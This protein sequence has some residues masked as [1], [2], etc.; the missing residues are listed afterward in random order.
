[1]RKYSI[2]QWHFYTNEEDDILFDENPYRLS[3]FEAVAEIDETKQGNVFLYRAELTQSSMMKYIKK[4]QIHDISASSVS[5]VS[6]VR[7]LYTGKTESEHLILAIN[8]TLF[9]WRYG[10]VTFSKLLKCLQEQE[11]FY[12][13]KKRVTLLGLGDV[14][15]MLAIGIK[16]LG[17]E[18]IES[19]GVFDI[20]EASKKRWEMELNQIDVNPHLRIDAIDLDGLFETDVFVF[21]ASKF[22]P[23]VGEEVRDVRM[24]QYDLNAELIE[25]YAQMARKAN[26]KGIFA[27]VSDPVDL[28]CNKAF[29]S[30]QR[31]PE[32]LEMD[33]LGL[34]PEQV[35]GFGLGVMDARAK[36]YSDQMGLKYRQNG[37]VFGQHGRDLVVSDNVTTED[38]AQGIA[39]THKVVHSNLDMRAL[40]YK[41]FIAPAMSSGAISI[42]KMLTGQWHYSAQFLNGIYWG[43]SYRWLSHGMQ[44]E[45]PCVSH[46]LLTRIEE[47]Y[48]SL[49]AIWASLS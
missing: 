12:L 5:S 2:D 18:G 48:R 8:L 6:P 41:P 42:V 3:P 39:L 16:L 44:I 1:M 37:R 30:S 49:E 46:A 27:V 40:G 38:Q 34:L 23:K 43:S 13:K 24:V 28:L 31:H 15:S 36:Y 26:F 33:Y 17:T 35:V 14:G 11:Q 45:T 47:T 4:E 29:Y 10:N 7:S 20:N 25:I 22:V 32:T 9:E 19:L 21:C